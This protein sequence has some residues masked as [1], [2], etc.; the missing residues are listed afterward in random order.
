[1][2][3]RKK[4]TKMKHS[5]S[6]MLAS[7]SVPLMPSEGY[8]VDEY[9]CETQCEDQ[10]GCGCFTTQGIIYATATA[11][12][13]TTTGIIVG[14]NCRREGSR[15]DRGDPGFGP[16]GPIGPRGPAGN[17]G[18]QGPTGPTGL[19]GPGTGPTG[20]TG[21][22]GP[23]GPQGPTGFSGPSGPSGPRG[24][25]GIEGPAE[26][27]FLFNAIGEPFDPGEVQ[28]TQGTWHGLVI[29]PDDNIFATKTFNLNTPTDSDTITLNP[30]NIKGS[31]T[32]VFVV[33]SISDEFFLN[34]SG[35][36]VILGNVV[37]TATANEVVTRPTVTTTFVNLT[38]V[39]NT[40]QQ[41]SFEFT[42]T[43]SIFD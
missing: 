42:Y 20:P 31:Y 12:A 39:R 29:T 37:V 2:I 11:I 10:C 40:G 17:Q 1:M 21:P 24:V 26:L 34:D 35:G 27:V 16:Q 3:N 4:L 6:L 25:I 5:L 13:A 33:D 8:A 18:P 36:G 19:T 43:T 23:E 7:L 14:N 32:L 9:C 22:R 38:P 15:G 30:P 41:V 28:T